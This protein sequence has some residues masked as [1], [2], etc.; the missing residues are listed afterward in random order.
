[1]EV[2]VGLRLVDVTGAAAGDR[3]ELDEL[4]A[5]LRRERLVEMSSS[6]ADSDARQ[7]L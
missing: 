1:M 5:E 7:P 6:F 3:L 2:E 4:D